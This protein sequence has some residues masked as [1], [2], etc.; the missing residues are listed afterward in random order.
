MILK[1]REI[2]ISII[3]LQ[4]LLRRLPPTHPK[5]PQIQE[6]LLKQQAGYKG[7]IAVDYQLSLLPEKDYRIFQDLRLQF[8]ESFFQLDTLILT[9]QYALSLEIKNMAGTLYFDRDY[10]QLIRTYEN[11]EEAFPDPILQ[12]RRHRHLFSKWL[13]LFGFQQ[14]PIVSLIVISS[15]YSIIRSSSPSN[16]QQVI[17][18]AFLPTKI[19]EIKS[20][21]PASIY[22]EKDIKKLSRLLLK[23]H[24]PADYPVLD[25]QQVN[26]SEILTGVQCP[27][28]MNLPIS[29]LHGFWYCSQCKSKSTDAHIHAL[30]DYFYLIG[31]TITSKELQK[32]LHISSPQLATRIFQSSKIP[33]TGVRKSTVYDLS[34]VW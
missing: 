15:P 31:P 1:K 2:P 30:K 4:A 13:A 17:H 33:F 8:N 16:H 23:L 5:I 32:F 12:S 25:R 22:S 26:K 19:D 11:K 20:T 3:K 24:T 18:S 27:S 29:R 7:E 10:H 9:P 21:Y 34:G 14:L 28:C 6:S